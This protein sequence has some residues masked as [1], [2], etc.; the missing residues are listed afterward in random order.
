MALGDPQEYV[1]DMKPMAI[2]GAAGREGAG[3]GGNDDTSPED[4]P[5]CMVS[6]RAL[7]MVHVCHMV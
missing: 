2:G 7:V 6:V 3:E 1:G 4:E 5:I